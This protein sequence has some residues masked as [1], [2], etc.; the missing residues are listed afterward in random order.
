M[1]FEI[2]REKWEE[3]RNK[4][5]EKIIKHTHYPSVLEDLAIY[6]SDD[7]HRVFKVHYEKRHIEDILVTGE[8]FISEI[9]IYCMSSK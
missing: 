2:D 8:Y 6:L 4:I 1:S 5:A 3:F 7:V 9:N